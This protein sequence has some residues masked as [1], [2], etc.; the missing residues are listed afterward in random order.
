MTEHLHFSEPRQSFHLD[1]SFGLN[2]SF[3]P[4]SPGLRRTSHVSHAS[5]PS[6]ISGSIQPA[7]SYSGPPSTYRPL[8]IPTPSASARGM[9]EPQH[10]PLRLV[11][12]L[13]QEPDQ[14]PE[15]EQNTTG[16]TDQEWSNSEPTEVMT[17]IPSADTDHGIA[18]GHSTWSPETS[19]EPE[20][21]KPKGKAMTFVGGFV[22]GLRRLPK[23]MSRGRLREH[24][25][26]RKGPEDIMD[27]GEASTPLPLYDEPGRPVPSSSNIQYVEGVQMP[28]EQPASA[29]LSYADES[30]LTDAQGHTSYHTSYGPSY[31]P[32][33]ERQSGDT[34]AAHHDHL[35]PLM[36]SPVMVEPQPTSD[37]DKMESPVRISK[38]DDSLSAHYTRLRKFLKD[39][40]DLPWVSSHV[41]VEY[42]PQKSSRARPEKMKPT[43]WYTAR[44]HQTIDLLAAASSR[45]QVRLHKDDAGVHIRPQPRSTTTYSHGGSATSRAGRSHRRENTSPGLASPLSGRGSSHT[46]GH[47]HGQNSYSYNYYYPTPQP[48]YVYPSPGPSPPSQ[49]VQPGQ[50]SPNGVPMS[51]AQ[52]VPM[53]MVA[54]PSPM[55]MPVA[56]PPIHAPTHIQFS[57]PS[58]PHS[59]MADTSAHR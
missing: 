54:A 8:P 51:P 34:S 40:H 26:T 58:A 55:V 16:P 38:P 13:D 42:I 52:P 41:T 15:P 17:I 39:L 35:P 22:S 31:G 18:Y 23:A 43:S 21:V 27:T 4:T 5:N 32:S 48:L 46:H 33:H 10:P 28:I 57:S 6:W 25:L 49:T 11:T 30:R 3:S 24:K 47:S 19:L 56:P 45:S 53:Y 59:G 44:H 12:P 14:Y 37:Y 2:D 1:P 29:E 36:T 7:Y 20:P 9:Y 50:P